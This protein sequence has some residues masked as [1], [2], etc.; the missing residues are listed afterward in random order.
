M[1]AS[2]PII[3]ASQLQSE[4]SL[5]TTEAEYVALSSALRNTIPLMRLVDELR[6]KLQ[7]PMDLIPTVK[8]KAFEDNSGAVELSNVHK[9]RPRTKHINTKYHHFRAYV[10]EKLIKVLQVSANDQIADIFTKNLSETL[11]LKFREKLL[12]W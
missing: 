11:F 12:G 4:I 9:M 1:Y 6:N 8:C 3:W 10:H 2:C 5:S 7:L